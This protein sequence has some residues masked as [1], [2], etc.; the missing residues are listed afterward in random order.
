MSNMVPYGN[1]ILNHGRIKNTVHLLS[2]K[3]SP[4]KFLKA[5]ILNAIQGS[6]SGK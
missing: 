1:F 3:E 6:S 2:H 5:Q 4:S